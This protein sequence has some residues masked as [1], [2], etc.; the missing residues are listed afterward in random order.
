MKTAT[1]MCEYAERVRSQAFLDMLEGAGLDGAA[2]RP[3][4]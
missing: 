4:A 2:A 3:A 1:Y